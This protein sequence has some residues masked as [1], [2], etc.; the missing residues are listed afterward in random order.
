MKRKTRYQFEHKNQIYTMAYEGG[1]APLWALYKG[2]QVRE[3]R[4]VCGVEAM[5]NTCFPSQAI[6][7]FKERKLK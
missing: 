3:S 2:C 4:Y 7:Y 5:G 6:E 1:F